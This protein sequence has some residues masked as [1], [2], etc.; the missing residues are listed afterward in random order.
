MCSS[1]HLSASVAEPLNRFP[2]RFAKFHNALTHYR[3][4]RRATGSRT[5]I[6]L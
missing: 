2:T 5:S 3:R 6:I 1:D 4:P